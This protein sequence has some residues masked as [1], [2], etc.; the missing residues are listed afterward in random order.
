MISIRYLLVMTHLDYDDII[1]TK[2]KL[3][4]NVN[5]FQL[6]YNKLNPRYV[7]NCINQKVNQ[8]RKFDSFHAIK[9]SWSV[10]K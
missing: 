3:I 6:F 10:Q 9:I 8:L 2:G 7:Y 4:V 1:A 5:L